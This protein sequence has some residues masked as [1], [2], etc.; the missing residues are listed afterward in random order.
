MRLNE[1]ECFSIARIFD[2]VRNISGNYRL[3]LLELSATHP[4][5]RSLL[6]FRFTLP[7]HRNIEICIPVAVVSVTYLNFSTSTATA[8]R[9]HMASEFGVSFFA[10]P[11]LASHPGFMLR[12]P[13]EKGP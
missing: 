4:V 7:P 3:D 5:W 1:L 2:A 6:N 13:I 11:L 10:P 8:P 12:V 9:W